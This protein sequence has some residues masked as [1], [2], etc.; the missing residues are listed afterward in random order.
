MLFR[1]KTAIQNDKK[2]K[3]FK[4]FNFNLSFL[5]LLSTN[6]NNLSNHCNAEK[7]LYS[8]M[9]TMLSNHYITEN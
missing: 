9:I 5:A 1:S 2:F 3:T 4:K 7:E 8:A 6:T